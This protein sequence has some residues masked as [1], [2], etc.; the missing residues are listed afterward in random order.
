MITLQGLVD[1]T[2][3]LVGVIS[4]AMALVGFY[5]NANYLFVD[6]SEMLAAMEAERLEAIKS[7]ILPN[8]GFFGS[9]YDYFY[10]ALYIMSAI[11][12]MFYIGLLVAGT[13]MA[14]C[15]WQW[16][17]LFITIIV[18]ETAY[19]Y[20]LPKFGLAS[21]FALSVATADPVSN[22]GLAPQEWSYFNVWGPVV[23][24]VAMVY[25]WRRGGCPASNTPLENRRG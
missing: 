24:L 6:Y 8:E 25:L 21:E 19:I 9:G 13:Q 12:T 3:R 16:V 15:R 5:Y 23:A 18:L 7:G 20:V 11:C 1:G 10:P 2:L 17:P 14:R 4:I 22:G